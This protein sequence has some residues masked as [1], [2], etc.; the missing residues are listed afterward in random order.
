[1]KDLDQKYR[2]DNLS[3]EELSELQHCF[4]RENIDKI[5]DAMYKHWMFDDIDTTDV[6]DI[7]INAIKKKV[8]SKIARQNVFKINMIRVLKVAVVIM[9][10][11]FITISI[12]LYVENVNY[13]TEEMVVV[14]GPGEK[15]S[16]TLPDGTKVTMNYNS[17]L[18]YRPNS[19]NKKEREIKF[20][21]E[22]YFEVSKRKECPFYILSRNFKVK[23]LG[24]S[25]N[26]SARENSLTAELALDTGSVLFTSVKTGKNVIL[27]P[28]QT[29]ILDYTTGGI[30]VTTKENVATAWKRGDLE[31]RNLP[32]IDVLKK[33]EEA[34]AVQIKLDTEIS[35]ND[36]FTGTLP[37]ARLN[38]A[39]EIIE[40]S[41]NIKA[42]VEGRNIVFIKADIATVAR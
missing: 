24:T 6:D 15:T 21:G 38:E 16:M 23:V 13:F 14:T 41:Y 37:T 9:L 7:R 3:I 8:D 31:F 18:C 30:T 19:Y 10:P 1:M 20:Y 34:F 28:S 27:Q 33:V 2:N 40:K 35:T 11:V 39:L 4:G 29:A 32:L 42:V 25:F 26:L 5:E 22:A 12:Y 36:L 17:Q